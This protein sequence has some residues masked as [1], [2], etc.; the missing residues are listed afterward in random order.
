MFSWASR[1]DCIDI[2]VS[3]SAN[4]FGEIGLDIP[5][6]SM[7]VIGF[8]SYTNT[9][10][11]AVWCMMFIDLPDG[12]WFGD[13]N[14]WNTIPV[15]GEKIMLSKQI[16]EHWII[17]QSKS[18]KNKQKR[19]K[20]EQLVNN[21]RNWH[22]IQIWKNTDSL[23]KTWRLNCDHPMSARMKYLFYYGVDN[24]NPICPVDRC[25]ALDDMLLVSLFFY[26]ARGLLQNHRIP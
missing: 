10:D 21:N 20:V 8:C 2:N 3:P 19:M 23:N 1:L 5:L 26:W 11:G 12:C 6:M 22:W 13:R 9:E 7:M 14:T 17:E 24:G 16:I 18:N 25:E 15:S 4:W